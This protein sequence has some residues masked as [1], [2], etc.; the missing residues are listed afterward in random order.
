MVEEPQS[1]EYSRG[2][3]QVHRWEFAKLLN[4]EKATSTR[5]SLASK[6][7]GVFE[8]N[9]LPFN[10]LNSLTL[11]RGLR[12][13]AS[14]SLPFSKCLMY[15]SNYFD[16]GWRLSSVRRLKNVICVLDWVPHLATATEAREGGNTPFC[17]SQEKFHTV[18]LRC[19]RNIS[20]AP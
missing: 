19:V 12:K 15:S 9:A 18:V 3:E 1:K 11:Y 5:G 2:N 17:T 6:L 20:E 7:K 4:A 14:P 8:K 10:E 16:P 13:G